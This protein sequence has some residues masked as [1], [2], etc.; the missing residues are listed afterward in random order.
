MSAN[1]W[2][3]FLGADGVHDWVVL[4]GGATAFFRT[5]GLSAAAVLAVLVAD[6]AREASQQPVMTMTEHGLTVRLTREVLQLEDEHIA[7][8]RAVSALAVAHGYRADRSAVQEVQV[9]VAARPADID[10]H[11]WRTVL[12]YEPL[13]NDSVSDPLAHSSTVWQQ[14]LDPERPLR[15][16]MHIDVSMAREHIADRLA[17]A[18]A[19]GGRIVDD[20]QAPEHWTLSDTAG[21]R[22]CL[23]AWPDGASRPPANTE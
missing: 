18:L 2:R 23:C 14:G 7:L 19:A 15:H 4:H 5:E 9:A 1:G 20:A 10:L 3:R 21:N 6:A 8:A 12:G 22:V 17:A 16:A 13:A 11:F